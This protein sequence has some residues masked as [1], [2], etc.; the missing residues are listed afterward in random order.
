MVEATLLELTGECN[1]EPVNYAIMRF[2]DWYK[3]D[4]WYGDGVDLHMDYY[5]SYVIHP[6]LLDVLEVMQKYAKGEDEFYQFLY[7]YLHCRFDTKNMTEHAYPKCSETI[8]K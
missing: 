1:M 8:I 2:K 4:G 7:L 5:N 6:M 3:G